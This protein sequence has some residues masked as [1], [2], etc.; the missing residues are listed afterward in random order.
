MFELLYEALAMEFCVGY[1]F[2]SE[3]QVYL[4]SPA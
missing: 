4:K 3:T 1:V 2:F